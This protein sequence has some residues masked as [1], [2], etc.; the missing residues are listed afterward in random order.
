MKIL[1]EPRSLNKIIECEVSIDETGEIKT[2]YPI[3]RYKIPGKKFLGFCLDLS[4]KECFA[5]LGVTISGIGKVPLQNEK[6]YLKI[7]EEAYE[8]NRIYEGRPSKKDLKNESNEKLKNHKRYPRVLAEAKRTGKPQQ[9]ESTFSGYE[10]KPDG[11]NDYVLTYVTPEGTFFT[12][13]VT[14]TLEY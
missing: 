8:I 3:G 12:K 6:E 4:E 7:R 11:N 10:W 1:A 14:T 5:L 13:D 9:I 2:Q